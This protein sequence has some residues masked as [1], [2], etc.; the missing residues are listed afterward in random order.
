MPARFS[1][2]LARIV[3]V[4]ALV[5]TVPLVVSAQDAIGPL[6][7][8]QAAPDVFS[9]V[10]PDRVAT[11]TLTY[12][13][14]FETGVNESVYT[15]ERVN[16][17][18]ANLIRIATRNSMGG[19]TSELDAVT[20]VP[21]RAQAV[22]F[23]EGAGPSGRVVRSLELRDGFVHGQNGTHPISINSEG[24]KILFSGFETV[25]AAV[26]WEKCPQIQAHV[27]TAGRERTQTWRVAGTAT[28][29]FNGQDKAVFEIHRPGTAGSTRYWITESAPYLILK[30]NSDEIPNPRLLVA[31]A[32]AAR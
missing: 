1:S 13:T 10:A 6:S 5:M 4:A 15:I 27:V 9:C 2:L 25:L 8:A 30:Q 31:Y 19:L 28:V 11:G 12:R 20:L 24:R 32:P 23:E 14:V 22:A 17:G 29:A 18:G 3:A 26:D 16:V 21:T 7:A